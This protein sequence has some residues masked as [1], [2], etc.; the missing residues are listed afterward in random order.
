MI[1]DLIL[2]RKDGEQYNAKDFYNDVMEY[3][4]VGFEITE[5]MDN[6]KEKDVKKA[7]CDYIINGEYN[8]EI[9]EYINSV[10]WIA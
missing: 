10:E 6:G 5:A 3:E 9:C 2:D 1:I 8:P 4:E 7:I